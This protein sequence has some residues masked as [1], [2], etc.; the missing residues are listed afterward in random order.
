MKTEQFWKLD[1]DTLKWLH[2]RN[3][4]TA[5]AYLLGII[6]ATKKQGWKWTFKVPEFCQEWGLSERSFYRAVSFLKNHNLVDWKVKGEITVWWNENSPSFDGVSVLPSVAETLPSVAE[7]LPSVAEKTLESQDGQDFEGFSRLYSDIFYSSDSLNSLS[8]VAL[9]DATP[10]PHPKKE[11]EKNFGFE[12]PKEVA[13]QSLATLSQES[14]INQLATQ[15]LV[16]ADIPLGRPDPFFNKRVDPSECI[17]NWLPDGPWKTQDG[18]LDSEF[19]LAIAKRWVKEYGGDLH[20]KKGD[21]LKHF[22]KDPANLAIEWEWYQETFLHRVANIEVRKLGGMDTTADE[23]SIIKQARAVLPLP[24]SMRVTESKNP[25]QVIEQAADYAMPTIAESLSDGDRRLNCFKAEES[26]QP[27]QLEAG[28]AVSN[29]IWDTVALSVKEQEQS[30]QELAP[31]GS[32]NALMYTTTPVKQEQT[33]YFRQLAE[34]QR[35]SAK[36]INVEPIS[37]VQEARARINV[38][39]S[40]K[41]MPAVIDEDRQRFKEQEKLGRKLT[42]WN[43]LLQSGIPSAIADVE[44]QARAQGYVVI[45]GQVSEVD[46]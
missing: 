42:Y 9:A 8:D 40:S 13:P 27:K 26:T 11:G 34:K 28:S 30:W 23:Q 12:I 1:I 46:F 37:S 22:K 25:L 32:E 16:K 41:S 4:I 36:P 3:L 7:T 17:W 10:T 31:E 33:D 44:R 39:T 29:D 43:S 24:E 14:K 5:T 38:L 19:Q 20:V 21:V 6:R 35:L 2:E 15:S 45:D 18:K